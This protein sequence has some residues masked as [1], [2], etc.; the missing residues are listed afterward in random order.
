[1]APQALVQPVR[2][3]V[4]PFSSKEF[5]VRALDPVHF[6]AAASDPRPGFSDC[7]RVECGDP[8]SPRS[9]MRDVIPVRQ[10]I[11]LPGHGRVGAEPLV[12][13]A[14]QSPPQPANIRAPGEALQAQH[15]AGAIQYLI[16]RG[17]PPRYVHRG[18][19]DRQELHPV[20]VLSQSSRHFD[21]VDAAHG[22]AEHVVGARR[23]RLPDLIDI[24]RDERFHRHLAD[25]A[26]GAGGGWP[27]AVHGVLG[28]EARHEVSKR[29]QIAV[30][31][32]NEI[33]GWPRA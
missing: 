21:G 20:P 27:Q 29:E 22:V 33:E 12:G 23:L 31:G 4:R 2:E 25:P 17:D 28:G 14:V 24:P 15:V 6:A 8:R 1:M 16:Q 3:H 30:A 26:Q 5:V 9:E 13:D 10:D 32:R 11:V 18:I 19:Q 7:K